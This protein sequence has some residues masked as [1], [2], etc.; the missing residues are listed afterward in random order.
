M[1][2]TAEH[3]TDKLNFEGEIFAY[4]GKGEISSGVLL[5]FIKGR[6][7]NF[8]V[9]YDHDGDQEL[10]KMFAGLS[11]ERNKQFCAV[12]NPGAGNDN[13]EGLLPRE[14]QFFSFSR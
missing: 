6:Y 7:N 4:G 1:L 13:I 11:M 14:N 9:T 5:K 2:R 3:G 12:G 8:F 10:Q